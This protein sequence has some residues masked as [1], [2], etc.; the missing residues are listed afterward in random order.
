[1]SGYTGGVTRSMLLTTLFQ[2]SLRSKR[3]DG[4]VNYSG[5]GCRMATVST[6]PG[7]DW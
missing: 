1:M 4:Q 2:K 3:N 7:V 6:L 5:H